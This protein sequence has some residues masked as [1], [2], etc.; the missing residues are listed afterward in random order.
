MRFYLALCV[1]LT[2]V[3]A[4][5]YTQTH[6][7]HSG[8]TTWT[9]CSEETTD[10]AVC[11]DGTTDRAAGVAGFTTLL[12][13]SSGST[14]ANYACDI[15]GGDYS[16]A[17]ADAADLSTSGFQMN[18]VS[19]SQTVEAISFSDMPV[20]VVWIKCGTIVDGGNVTVTVTGSR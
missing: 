2:A 1:L 15:Y 19:L 11:D 7:S 18:S 17:D 10:D 5:G 12:F 20:S 9:L 13:D 8:G 16:V 3:P 6:S 14:S 4:F